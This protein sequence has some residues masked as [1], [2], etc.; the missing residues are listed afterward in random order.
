[1]NHRDLLINPPSPNATPSFSQWDDGR[2][3]WEGK[4]VVVTEAAKKPV[5]K[6]R[7]VGRAVGWARDHGLDGSERMPEEAR[8]YINAMHGFFSYGYHTARDKYLQPFKDMLDCKHTRIELNPMAGKNGPP[9]TWVR[10]TGVDISTLQKLKPTS[11]RK[12]G[13]SVVAVEFDFTYTSSAPLQSWSDAST[14]GISIASGF[15]MKSKNNMMNR[16][17]MMITAQIPNEQMLFSTTFTDVLKD[18]LAIATEA[19]SVRVGNSPLKVKAKVWFNRRSAETI[20][21][22]DFVER[23]LIKVVTPE[24]AEVLRAWVAG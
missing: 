11:V 21:V 15:A 3:G 7:A 18:R 24:Q 8:P 5:D 9:N 22:L 19:E 12:V 23:H 6:C 10:G 16:V 2:D 1:M 20:Y 4:P 13:A 17:G 14:K